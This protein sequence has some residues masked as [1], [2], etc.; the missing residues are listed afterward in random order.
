MQQ[1]KLTR[2]HQRILANLLFVLEKKVESIEQMINCNSS[3]A[4]YSIVKVLEQNEIYRLLDTCS[5]LKKNISRMYSEIELKK[6]SVDQFQFVNT[7]Q[8]QMWELVSDAFSDKLKG[9]GEKL[10]SNAKSIDPYID[11][12]SQIV[13]Q[14]KV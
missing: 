5:Q 7:V 9:Y 2:T 13:N 14:L 12:L 10:R 11:E 1:I 6:R 3:H 4:S 8:S